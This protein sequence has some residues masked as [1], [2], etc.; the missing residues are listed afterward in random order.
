MNRIKL[1]DKVFILSGK[2]KG[3]TGIVSKV[4]KNKITGK[5][6]VLVEGINIFKK[7]VK[8]IPNKNKSGGII[9]VE[10]PIHYSNVALF[11]DS[12]NRH[13]RVFFKNSES[14]KKIRVLKLS[15]EVL[16]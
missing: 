6:F 14:S 2:D 8:S 1:K 7:H 4:L 16:N 13:S 3:K 5:T 9:T 15:K 10:K 12:M 11:S